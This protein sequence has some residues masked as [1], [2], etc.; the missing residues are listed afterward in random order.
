[1][2][3]KI[4][5]EPENQD[6]V[7]SLERR[8][9][10]NALA[11]ELGVK[12]IEDTQTDKCPNVYICLNNAM[13][14][15]LSAL[16]PRKEDVKSYRR[17]TIPIEV[18]AV[19]KLA[20]DNKMFEGYYI[21]FDDVK[22]D[23]MLMGWNFKTPESKEKNYTW[24]VNYYLMARWGDCALELPELLQMG[25]ERIKQQLIDNAVEAV[26]TCNTIVATPDAYVRK[27]LSNKFTDI[28][29]TPESSRGI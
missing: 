20:M 21:L 4:Y 10:Y 7:L 5:R 9:T 15:Q 13:E 6:M 29:L 28:N 2:E 14:K 23:P 16:C 8:E 19:L 18:L 24:N 26:N 25:Y 11:A 12:S 1:M 17:S 3:V 22:P 27:I